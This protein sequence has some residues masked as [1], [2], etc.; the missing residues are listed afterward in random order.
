MMDTGISADVTRGTTQLA[1]VAAAGEVAPPQPERRYSLRSQIAALVGGI[2]VA[3]G[4]IVV[5]AVFLVPLASAAG[6]CGGG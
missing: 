2:V 5:I 6:G 4:V 3:I 1:D